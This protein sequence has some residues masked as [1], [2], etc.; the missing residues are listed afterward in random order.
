ME[1]ELTPVHCSCTYPPVIENL[2]PGY[3]FAE[4]GYDVWMGNARGN[5][6]S[7]NHRSMNP[8]SILNQNFWRFSWDE[9]GNYDLPAFVDYILSV[10]GQKK[11][12]YVG[13]SQ[14][15]TTFLVLN[16]LRPEYSEKFISFQG[17][18]PA[19]F[20]DYNDFSVFNGLAPFENVI[21]VSAIF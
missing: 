19:S 6:Y 13:H 11:L 17:L 21:E 3:G 7:R 9:I 2:F 18:A 1:K 12:H 8:D 16:S 15:G 14:G 5:Y 10:T 20:F 4:A